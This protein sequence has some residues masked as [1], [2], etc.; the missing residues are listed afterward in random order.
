MKK[1]FITLLGILFIN[2]SFAQNFEQQISNA[3]EFVSKKEFCK[4]YDI[5]KSAL[6]TE[7]QG[8]KFE[9]YYASI[10][11]AN[12]EKNDDALKWLNVAQEK[13]LGLQNGEIEYIKKDENFR[14]IRNTEQFSSIIN[15]IEKKLVEKKNIEE[16]KSKEWIS[17]ITK[18]TIPQKKSKF[19]FAKPGFALYYST[20]DNVNV[21]YL[22]YVPKNYNPTKSLKAIIY[23]HGGIVNTEIFNFDKPEI[24]QEPIFGLSDK[25]NSII[26]YPFGKK[27]FGWLNQKKAFENIY[28]II[29][30]VQKTYNIDKRKIYLG[31]M[32][33]GGTATFWFASQRPSIFAGFY[34]ISANP[35][36]EIGEINFNFDKPFYEIHTKDDNVFKFEEVEKIYNKNKS[37]NWHFETI[38]NGGHG[39]IY[40]EQGSK[41]FENLLSKLIQ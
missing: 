33:N 10:S 25:F 29:E 2:Y 17:D 23:L 41:I 18:N 6:N 30:Q 11:A 19:N 9:Y 38:E 3:E 36:L 20:V 12:C 8:G 14:K 27:D 22:V 24:K 7:N 1:N 32:S 4:A 39:I 16:Q 26:I 21:P 37:K 31:G 40:Q 13:G 35:K 15:S 28:K 5:F 34:A